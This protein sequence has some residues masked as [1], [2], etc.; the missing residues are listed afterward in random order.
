MQSPTTV[1]STVL[2]SSTGLSEPLTTTW[3]L[4]EV[5]R[6]RGQLD[7]LQILSQLPS[8]VLLAHEV[9]EIDRCLAL[10]DFLSRA[11]TP[12]PESVIDAVGALVGVCQH[13]SYLEVGDVIQ[14]GDIAKLASAMSR[15]N[16]LLWPSDR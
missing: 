4:V 8:H 14:A 15:L 6:L 1:A 16:D 13:L 7:S 3:S 11:L 9:R 5:V 2:E 12:P 10:N